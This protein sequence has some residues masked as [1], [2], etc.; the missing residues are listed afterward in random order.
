MINILSFDFLSSF[1]TNITLLSHISFILASLSQTSSDK[2]FPEGFICMYLFHLRKP[3]ITPVV[4]EKDLLEWEWRSILFWHVCSFRW[5]GWSLEEDIFNQ[6]KYWEEEHHQLLWHSHWQIVDGKVSSFLSWVDL[7]SL[8]L[9][10]HCLASAILTLPSYMYI[11]L[12]PFDIH[13][14]AIL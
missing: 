6:F 13:C 1:L 4:P 9:T 14:C 10:C 12:G 11:L 3:S 7:L 5:R 2:G 8:F